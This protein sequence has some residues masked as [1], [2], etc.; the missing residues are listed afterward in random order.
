VLQ[1]IEFILGQKTKPLKYG[2]NRY[3]YNNET[4]I[5]KTYKLIHT[6]NNHSSTLTPAEKYEAEDPTLTHLHPDVITCI[7]VDEGYIYT[8]S[9]AG[10]I[11]LWDKAVR[12]YM[13]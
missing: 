11:S 3:I 4:Y 5:L 9:M 7:C 6:L 2:I 13:L 12:I 8:G 1:R 10:E